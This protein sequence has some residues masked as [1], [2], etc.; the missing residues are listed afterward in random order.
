[1][2]VVAGQA[3]EAK[4]P[5]IDI[6]PSPEAALSLS[7]ARTALQAAQRDF[8]LVQQRVEMKLATQSDLS[9]AQQTLRLAQSKLESLSS[10]GIEAKKLTAGLAG[11]VSKVEAEEGQVVAAGTALMDVVPAERVQ[12][13]LAVEPSA[14]GALKVGQ[15]V[16]VHAVNEKD[17]PGAD[18][19]VRLI[20]DRINPTSRLVDVY[21][22]LPPGAPLK[23][24]TFV[25]ANIVVATKMALI[26]PRQAV[27]P[28]ESKQV[29]FTVEGKKAVRHEVETDLEDEKNVELLGE[30]VKVGD[31]VV[32][33][34]N[35]ELK[36][37]M[38]VEVLDGQ[39]ESQPAASEKHSGEEKSSGDEKS[40]GGEKPNADGKSTGGEAAPGGQ[41]SAG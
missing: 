29:L 24:E 3:V 18:G 41:G 27:L 39:S 21:V 5:L 36:G 38:A 9:T 35:A 33:Q 28:Q 31:A 23:L 10:R 40:A 32:V 30:Q 14:A 2:L 22:T 15:K 6:E 19:A 7:D 34:G 37:D 12:V 1:V 20:T 8:G 4:T 11:L 17:V 26:V 25:H 16:H 13:R